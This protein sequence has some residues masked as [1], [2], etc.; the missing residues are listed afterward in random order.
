[1]ISRSRF[2]KP[3]PYSKLFSLFLI[4]TAALTAYIAGGFSF[5]FVSTAV[6][7]T[8]LSLLTGQGTEQILNRAATSVGGSRNLFLLISLFVGLSLIA[9]SIPAHAQLF[10]GAR[11]AAD[12]GVGTY[13]GD[14]AS[15]IITVITFAMW[16]L[17]AAGGIAVI[18]GGMLQN[19]MVLVGGLVL[20]FG[21]AILMAVLEFSDGLLFGT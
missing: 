7:V 18:A 17:I 11:S 16:A 9:H 14:D 6:V 20:F 5:L 21:V 2:Y 10:E 4:S 12:E 3:Q 8:G 15:N 19:V 1:M 13:I